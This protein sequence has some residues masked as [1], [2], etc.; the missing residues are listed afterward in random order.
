MKKR[1]SLKLQDT[2]MK[3]DMHSTESTPTGE[4]DVGQISVVSFV[5]LNPN[6]SL[7]LCLS[8]EACEEQ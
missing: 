4:E 8:S 6:I 2:H 3:Y 1:K 5:D 7:L